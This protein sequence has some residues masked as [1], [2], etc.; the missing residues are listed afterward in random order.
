MTEARSKDIEDVLASIRRLV[1]VEPPR[2]KEPPPRLVLTSDL[3]VGPGRPAAAPEDEAAGVSFVTRKAFTGKSLRER[4]A[5]LEAAVSPRPD[6]EPDGSEDQAPHRPT[7]L[8]ERAEPRIPEPR[9]TTAAAMDP[10]AIL[11]PVPEVAPNDEGFVLP[12]ETPHRPFADWQDAP[13]GGTDRPRFVLEPVDEV[14]PLHSFGGGDA[15]AAAEE[16]TEDDWRGTKPAQDDAGG[17][18][19]VEDVAPDDT[20]DGP[21]PAEDTAEI[22]DEDDLR[23]LIAEIVREEL[24]GELGERLTRNIRKLVRRE[25]MRALSASEFG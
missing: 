16:T 13:R 11:A 20:G 12:D 22:L 15:P 6:F 1:A 5:E 17:Y 2:G 21:E 24:Q 23:D 3:R 18:T 10:N 14:T 9:I 7:G 25:I 19:A 4:I 8:P